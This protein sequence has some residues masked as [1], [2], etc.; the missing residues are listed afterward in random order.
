[1]NPNINLNL[2]QGGPGGINNSNLI[3]ENI[4]INTGLIKGK[5]KSS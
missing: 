1:M 2:R 3:M 5:K 4:N